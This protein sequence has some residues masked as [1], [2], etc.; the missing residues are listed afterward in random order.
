MTIQILSQRRHKPF[1]DVQEVIALEI[2]ISQDDVTWYFLDVGSIP[3]DT[4]NLQAAL[5]VR[6]AE[7]F[8]VARS[9]GKLHNRN[10]LQDKEGTRNRWNSSPF[11][12]MRPPQVYQ[13]VQATIDGWKSAE[14]MTA[15]LRIWLPLIL[16]DIAQRE[17]EG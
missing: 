5:D 17:S 11:N 3:L 10:K 7:L 8:D 2:A 4:P 9:N 6:F 12:G 1:E 13:A 16:A 14:D 15:S